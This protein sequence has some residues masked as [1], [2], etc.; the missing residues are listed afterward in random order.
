[1][2]RLRCYVDATRP[3]IA[4]VSKGLSLKNQ[5]MSIYDKKLLSLVLAIARWSQYL[6]GRKFLVRTDQRAFKHLIDQI[7]HT[8]TQM[9]WI[10]KIMR[11]DFD[12]EYKKEKENKAQVHYLGFQ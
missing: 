9:K 7:L 6:S 2:Y 8:G 11:F 5:A 12:I 10:T 4:Y 3:P 1:M